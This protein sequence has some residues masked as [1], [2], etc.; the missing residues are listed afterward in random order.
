MISL[1]VLHSTEELKKLILENPEL[2]LLISVGE[3]VKGY[4]ASSMWCGKGEFLDC[5]QTIDEEV[6]YSDREM[7]ED[8]VREYYEYQFEGSDAEFDKYIKDKLNE[9]EPYWKPCILVHVDV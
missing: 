4:L 6:T 9:Y 2:P 5:D 3:E 8:D 1:D 7:F